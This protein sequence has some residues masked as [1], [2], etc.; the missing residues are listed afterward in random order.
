MTTEKIKD[1]KLVRLSDYFIPEKFRIVP[2]DA[3]DIRGG[4]TEVQVI[5]N[6]H[7]KFTN[8]LTFDYSSILVIYGYAQLNDELRKI[9]K[10]MYMSIEG[11]GVLKRV[12]F[13]DCGELFIIIFELADSQDKLVTVKAEEVAFLLNNCM[14]PAI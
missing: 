6:L 4:M 11:K 1:L 2:R 13:N 7:Q 12:T 10:H 14:H 5:F 8:L 3:I 9:N